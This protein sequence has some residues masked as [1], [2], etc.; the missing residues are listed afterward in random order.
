MKPAA[1]MITMTTAPTA[2]SATLVDDEGMLVVE[3]PVIVA[4]TAEVPVA[5]MVGDSTAATFPI[6]FESGISPVIVVPLTLGLKAST[7]RLPF[8]YSNV[9]P[10]VIDGFDTEIVT[11]AFGTAA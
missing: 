8:Q 2:N 7:Q 9:N 5:L 4:G 6:K 10:E 3:E 1:T 11:A